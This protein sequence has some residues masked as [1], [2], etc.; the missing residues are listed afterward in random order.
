MKRFSDEELK[1]LR[2]DLPVRFVVE[3]LLRLPIKNIEGVVRYLCP[4]CNEFQT[5]FNPNANMSRCWRCQKNF[6]SIEIFMAGNSSSFVESVK[7][8]LPMLPKVAGKAPARKPHL[9]SCQTIPSLGG[10]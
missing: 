9:E 5:S 3:K 4:L 6:N 7:T 1:R 8:L 10:H 2:N